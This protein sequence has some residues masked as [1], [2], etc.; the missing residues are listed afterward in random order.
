MQSLRF[1]VENCWKS[2]QSVWK[3][4]KYKNFY[5]DFLGQKSE[6]ASKRQQQRKKKKQ[7]QHKAAL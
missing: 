7:Q 3:M 2:V 6:R 4:C 1:A 5:I